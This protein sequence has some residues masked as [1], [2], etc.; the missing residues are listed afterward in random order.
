MDDNKDWITNTI[1]GIND[2][3]EPENDAGFRLFHAIF[4]RYMT[5]VLSQYLLEISLT[6]T[7]S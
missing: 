6:I 3:P 7:I 5:L 2:R 1:K 4:T